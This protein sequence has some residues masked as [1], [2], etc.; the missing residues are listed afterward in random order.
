MGH[1]ALEG[2]ALNVGPR[3]WPRAFG[4]TRALEKAAYDSNIHT[5]QITETYETLPYTV[6]I[7]TDLSLK[8]MLRENITKP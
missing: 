7:S 3:S 5:K 1:G 6:Q 8:F 2:P 4:R